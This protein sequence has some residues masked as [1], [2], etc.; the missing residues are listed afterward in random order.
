MKFINRL[1]SQEQKNKNYRQGTK[2]LKR[3][4]NKTS[5][6]TLNHSLNPYPNTI[7]LKVISKNILKYYC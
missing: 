4:Y 7:T 1:A 5:T 6:I 2:N 3:S